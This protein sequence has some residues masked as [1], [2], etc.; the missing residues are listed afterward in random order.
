MFDELLLPYG[1]SSG[2]FQIINYGTGLINKTWKVSS[3]AGNFIL[4]S[5][6]KQVFTSPEHIAHNHEVLS[7]YL[8][9]K[10]P[11]YL[12][13]TPVLTADGRAMICTDS[14]DYFRLFRFVENSHTVDAITKPEEGYEAAKQFGKFTRL[15]S[16]LD[17]THLKHTL[18][19]FHNL[20]LRYYQYK[21]ALTFA[22]PERLNA[23]KQAIDA[24]D[25]GRDIV[26]TFEKLVMNNTITPRTIHHDTK[27]S[28][29][30]FDDND[31]GICVIDLDTVMPG[32]YISD[33]GDMLRTYLS[34][35]T[36]ED[37]DFDQITIRE[38]F[39]RAIYAGYMEEMGDI[40]T[41][42]EKTYFLFAG[43]FMIYMQALRFLTDF[44]NND[45][46]YKVAYPGH[47]LVRAEN[48]LTYL[49]KFIDKE[50]ELQQ[51]I[52]HQ[53]SLA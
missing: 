50:A 47:N 49:H 15:L 17:T 10:Y 53:C 34:P 6:N 32:L 13:V 25:Q 45:V 8:Q 20:P 21:D 37:K 28:N 11:D 46:Y 2:S 9:Q 29:V 12:L 1:I 51:I 33:V 40:L 52:N 16:D 7:A 41:D 4:Q 38:D 43:K 35:T 14:G 36:E 22:N 24:V 30:L 19:D 31:L 18:P 26:E 3:T 44:L 39:F 23:A 5:I 27:I 48:Q 42:E